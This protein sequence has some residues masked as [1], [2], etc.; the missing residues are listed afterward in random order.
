MTA[1]PT[2]ISLDVPEPMA[3]CVADMRGRFDPE[4]AHL[5]VEIAVTGSSGVGVL[6]RH[7]KIDE[8]IAAIQRVAQTFFPITT[9]FA[10]AAW[11]EDLCVYGLEV[12]AVSP[13][14]GLHTALR[15]SGPQ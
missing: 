12:E 15:H 4:F 2:Y 8:A 14:V 5:P 13:L 6:A 7:T 9:N 1:H 11:L 3:A 10:R